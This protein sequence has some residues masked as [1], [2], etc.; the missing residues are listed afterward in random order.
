MSEFDPASDPEAGDSDLGGAALADAQYLDTNVDGYVDSVAV[1]N[2]DGTTDMFVDQNQNGVFEGAVRYRPDGVVA[3]AFYDADENG[4]YEIA[5]IDQTGNGVLDTTVV[6]STGDNQLD[7]VVADLNENGVADT[8]EVQAAP[9]SGIYTGEVWGTP[10]S[11]GNPR[12]AAPWETGPGIIGPATN[13]DPLVEL[14]IGIAEET[15]RVVFPP[16]D[17]DHD[18]WPDNDDYHPG[19]PFRH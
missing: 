1:R 11:A 7:T 10:G 13:P 18:G 8:Q 16:D 4:A 5:V 17:S 14:I 2:L 9:S 19:D 15:G 6:D 3:G 12:P